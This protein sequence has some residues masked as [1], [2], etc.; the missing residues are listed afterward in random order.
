MPEYSARRVVVYAAVLIAIALPLIAGANGDSP[1]PSE[2]VTSTT[3]CARAAAA[4]VQ[5]HYDEVRDWSA[6]FEQVT[7]SVV[8][9]GGSLADDAPAVG[10]VIFEKPGKMRWT[11]ESPPSLV[12]SDGESLW[13]YDPASREAQKMS[14]S[15]G[16][17]S[18][19]AL[20]FLMGE[21]DLNGAFD[22]ESD[23][24]PAE[25]VRLRLSPREPASY[26]RLELLVDPETGQVLETT[27]HDILGNRTRVAF[28]AVR[29]DQKPP[30][31]TFRFDPEPG[32]RVTELEMN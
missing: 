23:E 29:T 20:L 25:R 22:V 8:L 3:S 5:Q 9:G 11:Y 32:V 13:I 27:I 19:A 4:K 6:R 10:Q 1:A 7:K 15:R 24:C 31:E 2:T 26:E 14:V 30:A 16:G 28:S 18:G 17:L 21:G 12:V